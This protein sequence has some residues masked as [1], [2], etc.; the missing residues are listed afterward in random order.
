M[1]R[2]SGLVESYPEVQVSSLGL[3]GDGEVRRLLRRA[4]RDAWPAARHFGWQV[5]SVC[6]LDP[7][8]RDVG[9]TSEDGTIYVKVRDPGK[10]NSRFYNYSFVLATLLHEMTHLSVLG[11]GK[12]FYRQLVEAVAQCGAEPTLKREVRTHVSAEL[13]NAVCENDARRAKAVLSVMPEAVACRMPG[14]KQQLP[15]EYAAHHGRVALTKLLIE[16]RAE[17]DAT[18]SNGGVPP[19]MR[20]A[21][22]GNKRTAKVLLAA[23]AMSGQAA[24]AMA[25]LEQGQHG[26]AALCAA[27]SAGAGCGAACCDSAAGSAASSSGLSEQP[28]AAKHALPDG[29]P[30]RASSLPALP[31]VLPVS[32]A[33]LQQLLQA[34]GGKGRAVRVAGGAKSMAG[35]VSM[36][37]GSLAL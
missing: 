37:S 5:G 31:T 32:A 13:L 22:R 29:A 15:L 4:L 6:E 25:L 11:H 7:E 34:R 33:G 36:L 20:A 23:G 18:C 14:A 35:R 17:V 28:S 27:Y 10:G 9:Y 2:A 1:Q 21:A 16:A 26:S 30:R 24:D 19:L 3:Y 12:A 8:N